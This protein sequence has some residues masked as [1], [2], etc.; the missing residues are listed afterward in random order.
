M[1]IKSSKSS[2]LVAEKYYLASKFIKVEN[3]RL[4]YFIT[5]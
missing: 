2:A 1:F 4:R 3:T 5:Y